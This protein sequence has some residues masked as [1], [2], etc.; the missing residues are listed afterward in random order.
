[1]VNSKKSRRRRNP[2]TA[3]LRAL[4]AH[5]RRLREQKGFSIDRLAKESEQLSS[6]VIHRLETG[7]G[8]VTVTA[9]F[10]F[11][12][13]LGISPKV[14]FDFSFDPDRETRVFLSEAEV[15]KGMFKTHLPVYSLKAAAGN[16]GRGEAVE[17][18]GWLEVADRG[19][20]RRNMFV[21]QAVGQSME[22]KIKDGDLLVFRADPEGTRQG[23]IVLAQY[24]GPADPETG[25]GFTVKLYTSPGGAE[26]RVVLKP[27]NPAFKPLELRKDREEDFRVIAE[28]LFTVE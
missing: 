18:L 27:L 3:F 25:G 2:P 28:Y 24:R 14:L 13:S 6:S 8:S 9:L 26:K 21:A 11:A 4:G 19:T 16:F 7:S 17:P 5:C 20:L 10:R 1:M 12:Q 15:G 23:K 22:P